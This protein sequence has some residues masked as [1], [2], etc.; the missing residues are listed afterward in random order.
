MKNKCVAKFF[1]R[2]CDEFTDKD[3]FI[4]IKVED[5]LKLNKNTLNSVI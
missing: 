3:W 5:I 4:P 2:V 1:K